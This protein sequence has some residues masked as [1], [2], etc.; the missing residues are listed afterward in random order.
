VSVTGARL[1]RSE[2]ILS[3]ASRARA[4]RHQTIA[5]TGGTKVRQRTEVSVVI[6]L[7]LHASTKK[8]L[9]KIGK[10]RSGLRLYLNSNVMGVLCEKMILLV[11]ILINLKSRKEGGIRVA[12]GTGTQFNIVLPP[13]Q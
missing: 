8:N 13:N 11:V 1:L 10:I 3:A 4:S 5:V 2:E 12:L 6:T 7:S 9:S